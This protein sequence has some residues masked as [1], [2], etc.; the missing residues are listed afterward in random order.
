MAAFIFILTPFLFN[1]TLN[2]V[3]TF[4]TS[5]CGHVL[6]EVY[7]FIVL[8]LNIYLYKKIITILLLSYMIR[9][10]LPIDF[11]HGLAT[12]RKQKFLEII[13]GILTKNYLM[14][15]STAIA[16]LSVINMVFHFFFGDS[17]L[18]YSSLWLS[19]I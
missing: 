1:I 13:K 10:F 14:I 11:S 2:I 5:I 18:F 19:V 7:R 15:Y 12:V 6:Y 17:S 3:E 4:K 16:I 8:L 9:K